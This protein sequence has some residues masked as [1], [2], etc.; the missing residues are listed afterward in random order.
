MSL[1][2][3]PPAIDWATYKAKIPNAA[4]VDAIKQQYEAISIPY[5]KSNVDEMINAKEKSLVSI[6]N[7]YSNPCQVFLISPIKI[8]DLTIWQLDLY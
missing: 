2:E 7:L 8:E 4:F 6:F 5:P 3:K 1:P